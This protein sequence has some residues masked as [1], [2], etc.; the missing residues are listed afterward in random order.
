MPDTIELRTRDIKNAPKVPGLGTPQHGFYIHTM[1]D[2]GIQHIVAAYPSGNDML[3]GSLKTEYVQY[4]PGMQGPAASDF[5]TDPSQYKSVTLYKG[6]TLTARN[7]MNKIWEYGQQINMKTPDYKLPVCDVL[8][9]GQY[10]DKCSQSNSNAF[11]KKSADYAGLKYK[12]PFDSNGMPVWMPGLHSDIRDTLLDHLKDYGGRFADMTL[13]SALAAYNQYTA[14]RKGVV[15]KAVGAMNAA[16]TMYVVAQNA[17]AVITKSMDFFN[18][19]KEQLNELDKVDE[20]RRQE[21]EKAAKSDCEAKGKQAEATYPCSPSNGKLVSETVTVTPI[22][23]GC[24]PQY[25]GNGHWVT[26]ICM[27]GTHTHIHRHY[28]CEITVACDDVRGD[29]Q[30]RFDKEK[31]ERRKGYEEQKAQKQRELD[32]LLNELSK[33]LDKNNYPPELQSKMDEVQVG[34][35]GELN[36]YKSVVC[37]SYHIS[38]DPFV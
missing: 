16:V 32:N 35:A 14:Y 27:P 29:Y 20:N 3:R 8:N 12:Q 24:P 15:D 31:A 13:D 37:D 4:Y 2:N 9:F 21:L 22:F 25:A 19:Q 30:G 23:G 38:H 33:G 17:D 18:W 10:H 36:A 7:Y 28:V 1:G 6:D 34:L 26:P 5:L 11:I